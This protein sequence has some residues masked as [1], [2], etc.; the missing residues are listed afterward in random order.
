MVMKYAVG[1]VVW[2][3][4][5]CALLAAEQ[6]W[7]DGGPDKVWSVSALNWDAGA[8]WVNGNTARFTGAGGTQAGET[9]DVS[10]DVTVA[11]MTF[12]TNG[13][14]IADADADGTLTLD[15]TPQ[16]AVTSATAVAVI[17]ETLA[18]NGGFTKTGA[19][20][21]QL[22]APN[23]YAGVTRVAEGTLRLSKSVPDALGATGSGNETI[24][25]DGATLD[26]ASAFSANVAEDFFICGAGVDGQGAFVNN[27]PTAYYNVGYRNLT[28]TG[29]AV[30]GGKQRFDMAGNGG[31][32]TGNGFTLTK[33]GACE[34]AVTR[35]VR[36]SPIVINAGTYTMQHAEALGGADYPTTV[37][38]GT[39]NG[40]PSLTLTE[41]IFFNGG[42]VRQ[43][44]S[45]NTFTMAG[46]MTLSNRVDVTCGTGLAAINLTGYFDGPGGFRRTGSGFC[47]LMGS[48]NRYSGATLIDWGSTL[49]VGRAN[50]SAGWFGGG[51][52][53]NNGTLY[54]DR[55][56]SVVCSNGFFG[57][58]I[59]GL[60]Y[61][62]DLTIS[63]SFSSNAILHLAHGSITLTNGAEFCVYSD[64]SIANRQHVGYGSQDAYNSYATMLTN[65]V[66]TFTVND[67]CLLQAKSITFGNGGDL[68][69]GTMTGILNQVGGT[70]RTTGTAA[71][72][73]GI[74][75]GHY[76][77]T[78]SFYNMMGG[79]LVVE[80]DYD[81][82]C[83]TDGSGWFNMTGG[84]VF[85]K[86]VM[87]NERVGSGGYGRL[88]VA[89]GTLNLGSLTGSDMA[90][91][92]GITVDAGGPYRVEFGGAGGTIRA[93][94]NITVF[95]NAT[96]SGTGAEAVHFDPAG[97]E[98]TV[99]GNLTGDGGLNKT[100]SGT[101]TL[102]GNNTYTGPT[103][104]LQG[105]LVRGAYT[106]LPAMGEVH[107]GVTPNNDGGRLRADGDLVLEGLVVGVA[108]PED[109]DK[110]KHYTIA[111]WGGGLSSGFSGSVLPAPWYVHA[112][113]A[114]K[115]LELRAEIGTL[116]WLR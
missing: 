38:G 14:V 42:A 99:S 57:V 100:G 76:P 6:V 66:A 101:L 108:N 94:T 63:G 56:G 116:L 93:V 114:N 7:L 69:G 25:E 67:G 32:Y 34:V 80:K 104:I 44:A 59:V 65:V 97:W 20:I 71:E 81:L 5:V 87:L 13:Y 107:F 21:L 40:W 83:A 55:G 16:I 10:G 11:G 89:G 4:S 98:I 95:L 86:R 37:N 106:G 53:T 110:S 12:E 112:D 2:A 50:G 26:I 9:I 48:S 24:V 28:L 51:A 105:R 17:Q 85:V 68:V 64:M 102:S 1:G 74:R 77:Q 49:H 73:N 41:R 79:T 115:R 90:V 3:C 54:I 18:G 52:V 111:T 103:R 82:G 39:L 78:R 31:T 23:T 88:T 58:G 29:D 47:Y 27:G 8:G 35:A 30:I 72:E 22:A 109:L 113:W 19:G 84:E 43:G 60:R 46:H 61:G 70:V 62:L 36:N 33:A 96:L 45:S 91:S 92:N 75:L 15:G